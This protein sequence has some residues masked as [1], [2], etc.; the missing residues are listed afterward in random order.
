MVEEICRACEGVSLPGASNEWSLELEI[1]PTYHPDYSSGVENGHRQDCHARL[2]LLKKY[3]KGGSLLDLG[4]SEGF[5]SFSFFDICDVTGIE[6]AEKEYLHCQKRA[7]L[8]DIDFI[9]GDILTSF[10]VIES[11]YWDTILYMSVHHHIIEQVGME[12]A[13]EFLKQI[14]ANGAQMFFDMGQKNENCPQ[15]EW[16][17]L[18]PDTDDSGQWT[19]DYLKK[20]TVYDN[21]EK[22]G[23]SPIHGIQRALWK[24]AMK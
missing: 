20:N 7:G 11:Q 5:Y 24:L 13:T 21:I 22:I 6:Q 4:C 17:Q 8:I 12:K 1:M 2:K 14:S 15:H 19:H 16:H 10:D 9:R 3:I 18:L 23:S